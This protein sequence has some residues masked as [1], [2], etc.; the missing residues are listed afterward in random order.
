MKMLLTIWHASLRSTSHTLRQDGRMRIAWLIGL[1]FQLTSSLWAITRLVPLVTSWQTA[2]AV[3]IQQHLWIISLYAWLSISLFTVLSTMTYGLNSQEALLLATQPIGHDTRARALYGLILLKGIAHWLL[4][5]VSITGVA[6]TFVLGWSALPWLILLVVGAALV[7]WLTLIATLL[8]LR[9]VLPYL[10]RVLALV[11]LFVLLLLAPILVV[12]LIKQHFLLLTQTAGSNFAS[13]WSFPP[14]LA[15]LCFLFLLCL[16]LLPLASL[17]GRLY[18]ATLQSIQGRDNASQARALPGVGLLLAFFKR[19]RT[20]TAALLVKGLLNQSRSA[21]AWLRL[22]MLAV[23][24]VLFP[25]FRPSLTALHV[26]Q[27]FQVAG[28]ASFVAFLLLFEYAP[29][30]ISS[31]GNRLALYLVTPHGTSAFVCARLISFLLPALLAGLLSAFL[32]AFETNL[33]PAS[34]LATLALMLLLLLGSTCFTVLGSALDTNLAIAVEDRMEAL[35]QEELPITPRRLQ[36]LALAVALFAAM[37]WLAWKL[38]LLL[39]LPALTLLDV[40]IMLAMW[41]MS[42][43]YLARLLY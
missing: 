32:L 26:E 20:L 21:F 9:F 36:L 13:T 17:T 30:A 41:R 4:V 14:L 11:G 38:P 23:L 15:S 22:L 19:S 37:L 34:L 6:L 33:A 31:E 42:L 3:S 16:A 2:G 25:L 35:M 8:V 40:T 39:S 18:L 12:R 43:M 1:L 5:E 29:Y 7:C 28:Y 24:L 10:R 27:V